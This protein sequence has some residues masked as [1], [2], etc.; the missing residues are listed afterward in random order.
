MENIWQQLSKEISAKVATAGQ[1]VVAVNGRAGHASSGIVWRPNYVFTAFHTIRGE[2]IEVL[3]PSGKSLPARLAGRAPASDLALLKLDTPIDGPDAV[4]GETTSLSV[5][6]LVVAIGRTRRGNVVAS[7]GILSG[8]MGEWRSGRSRIDQFIRPDL[9]LYPGFS[10]GALIDSSGKILGMVTSGLLA[11]KPVTIPVSTLNRIGEEL[12]ARGHTAS[13]YIGLVMQP[14]SI[15]ERLQ[16]SSGVS[17]STGLLIM[18]VESASPADKGGVLLGDILVSLDGEVFEA[19]EDLQDVLLRRGI[20]QNV[21][22]VLIRGG[23]KVELTL[24]IGER[25]IR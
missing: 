20:N 2:S 1:S 8:L 14:V 6:E 23:Q 7:S 9:T 4:F 3:T 13:P 10:G 12:A 11:R 17:T 16:K 15:P 25:S 5:G 22:A 19:A 18:H 21:Q 24:T